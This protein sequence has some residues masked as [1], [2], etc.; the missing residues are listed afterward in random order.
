MKL[1]QVWYKFIISLLFCLVWISAFAT[2]EVSPQTTENMEVEL[3]VSKSDVLKWERFEV[4]IRIKQ[5][6]NQIFQQWVFNMEW[7]DVFNVVWDRTSTNMNVV[8]WV[9]V[10]MIDKNLT[11]SAPSE[12]VFNLW[13]VRIDH[14]WSAI[15]SNTVAVRVWKGNFAKKSENKVSTWEDELGS[16][17]LEQ[18]WKVNYLKKLL[19]FEFLLLIAIIILAFDLINN[20]RNKVSNKI[21]NNKLNFFEVPAYNDLDF[22]EKS[23]AILK[24]YILKSSGL[25]L[26]SVNHAQ[27]KK[28][29]KDYNKRIE[30]WEIIDRI[31]FLSKNN[32]CS[33]EQ[34]QSIR[35]Q[36]QKFI[37]N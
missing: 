12:W 33:K 37:K 29:W 34:L 8:N 26:A 32:E 22:F 21:V 5:K 19:S 28:L 20:K 27:L 35:N 17:L 13:P 7:L 31:Y 1:V 11:L 24:D 14:N 18:T 3:M 2:W 36:I 10:S 9:A 23:L 4:T 30:L 25:E 16:N 6:W 15:V